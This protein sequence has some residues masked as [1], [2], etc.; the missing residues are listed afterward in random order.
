MTGVVTAADF[1]AA[2][3]AAAADPLFDDAFSHLVD[4]RDC[5]LELNTA[6]IESLAARSIS[7]KT[8]RRALVATSDVTF[9]LGR[10]YGS[11]RELAV[12]SDLT[13]VF[14]SLPAAFEWLGIHDADLLARLESI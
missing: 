8:T 14:R 7:K 13:R 5:R 6:A 3:E 4:L 10:M 1:L 12:D 9:G 11:H 2:R